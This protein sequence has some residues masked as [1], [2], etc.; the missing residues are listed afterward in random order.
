MQGNVSTHQS[1]PSIPDGPGAAGAANGS[2]Q[3]Q[4][5]SSTASTSGKVCSLPKFK[6]GSANPD[7]KLFIFTII[8]H[9][10]YNDFNS[11]SKVMQRINS[12]RLNGSRR[13]RMFASQ[14]SV[15][16]SESQACGAGQQQQQQQCGS[17]SGADGEMKSSYPCLLKLAVFWQPRTSNAALLTWQHNMDAQSTFIFDPRVRLGNFSKTTYLSKIEM[18]I[19]IIHFSN[20]HTKCIDRRIILL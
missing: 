18:K 16:K 4:Q 5:Q 8:I 17:G 11:Y 13:G 9:Q 7:L 12:I 14:M 19:T 3:L 1:L 15:S 20:P 2:K 10:F 6:G